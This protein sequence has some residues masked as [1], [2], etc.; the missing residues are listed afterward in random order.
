METLRTNVLLSC[1]KI[2]KNAEK[3]RK[4]LDFYNVKKGNI[5]Q[6][7]CCKKWHKYAIMTTQ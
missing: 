4:I 5:K 7:N 1:N 6:L 3:M 2:S